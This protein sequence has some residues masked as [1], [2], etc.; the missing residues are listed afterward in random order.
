[1]V[2]RGTHLQ[3]PPA[4][5]ES[6]D[7]AKASPFDAV[8][9]RV[10][11]TLD[12]SPDDAAAPDLTGVVAE[13]AD[14]HE[15]V[16]ACERVRDAGL[17]KWDSY[18]PYPV[19]GIERAMGIKPTI[20]PWLALGG[21]LTGTCTGLLMQWYMNGSEE[22]ANAVGIPTALQGYNYLISGKPLWSIPANIPVSFELT[23]LFA[24]FGSFFG[25]L[26]LNGLPRWSNPRFRLSR[27]R[28]STDD[29]FLIGVDAKDPKF[30]LEAAQELL[31]PTGAAAVEE[32]WDV[33]RKTPPAWLPAAGLVAFAVLLIPPVLIAKHR[34][35]PWQTPRIH[36]V[37]D[38]DWQ[39]KFKPQERNTFFADGR[40]MR[41]Q[42]PG[43]IARGELDL[44]DAL[45]RGLARPAAVADAGDARGR[46]VADAAIL[47]FAAW[48]RRQEETGNERDQQGQTGQSGQS[49][50]PDGNEGGETGASVAG[51]GPRS[52]GEGN[53]AT[54]AAGGG[55]GAP[56]DGG[57]DGNVLPG[58]QEGATNAEGYEYTTDLPIEPTLKA[59]RRGKLVFEIYCAPCHGVGGFGNGLVNLRA[60]TL[61]Q[62]TWLQPSNLHTVTTRNRPNG[63]LYDAIT[64][65]VRKMPAYG[66]QIDVADRW[67]IVLYLRALQKSQAEKI[68]DLPESARDR[69]RAE[70]RADKEAEK[71]AAAEEAARAAAEAKKN[72]TP[73]PETGGDLPKVG[74]DKDGD[75][76]AEGPVDGKNT[77]DSEPTIV[78]RGEES[79]APEASSTA[80]PS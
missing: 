12:A 32:V 30:D 58:A 6:A 16:A 8:L 68:G 49:P 35:T 45:N 33:E 31:A 66:T 20:L 60:Q 50:P 70:A 75:G 76:T 39:P 69:A 67:A 40:A 56:T 42:V 61:G 74:E 71:K 52:F 34:N 65:G 4:R 38:M 77:P 53:E 79:D 37:G 48:T 17:T 3:D 44:D 10:D 62:P 23:I 27:F 78:P 72:G 5:A 11:E 19:H 7:D 1:M 47:S 9:A 25:M 14:E 13:Y 64:N 51:N 18:T 57:A 2:A 80:A 73:L 26:L 59:A 63:Y 54:D 46:A 28:R 21:G 24:A 22:L 43:T 29:R 15:L 55:E 36:P 41:P